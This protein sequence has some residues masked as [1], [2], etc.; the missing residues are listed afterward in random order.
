MVIQDL[1]PSSLTLFYNCFKEIME[2]GYG[3]FPLNLRK[4]F[5]EKLYTYSNFAFWLERNIRKIFIV[6]ESEDSREI[7][8]F[9][10]GDN[11][12]GGVAFIS[13]LGVR[14]KFRR[15]GIGTRLL[16]EYER[17]V[18][19]KSA[20]LIELYTQPELVP[21]YERFGYKQ[22]GRRDQGF[23]GQTNVI[24]NKKLGEWDESILENI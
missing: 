8:A 16:D 5:I 6:K 15:K 11:T 22:I 10:V 13:W 24:M 14:A 12:Y 1:A 3:A 4:Y 21:Y 9:L 20:H 23:F 17:N 18:R 7:I 2:E 19:S